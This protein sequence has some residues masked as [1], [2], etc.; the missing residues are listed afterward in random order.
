MVTQEEEGIT[1]CL[2]IPVELHKALGLRK[3]LAAK[4]GVGVHLA[5]T[6]LLG[7]KIE[8]DAQLLKQGDYRASRLRKQSVV[9]ASN[10]ERCAHTLGTVFSRVLF[11]I[12]VYPKEG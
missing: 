8:H 9:V 12:E 6:S 11:G 10:K 5:A 4:A 2:S 7:G 1:N 3:G